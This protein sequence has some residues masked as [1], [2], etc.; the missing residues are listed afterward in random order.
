MMMKA[1]VVSAISGSI[2]S[3]PRPPVTSFTIEAPARMAARATLPFEVSIEIGTSIFA[4]N[5]SIT[6]I[7]RRSS[8]SAAIASA[9]GRVDS[10]PMSMMSAPSAAILR[11]CSIALFGSKKFPPSENESG[12]TFNTPMTKPRRETLKARSPI[13]QI[14]SRIT[15]ETITRHGLFEGGGTEMT[16]LE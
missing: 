5:F 16:K 9:P 12:V 13:F 8:S 4:R 15:I 1:E 3:S 10:P 14:R 11:P 7:T 2:S 6:G